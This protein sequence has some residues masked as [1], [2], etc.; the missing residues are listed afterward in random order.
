MLP[1]TLITGSLSVVYHDYVDSLIQSLQL[2]RALRI[3][4]KMKVNAQVT[5]LIIS[6]NIEP[7]KNQALGKF[8]I[9]FFRNADCSI[10]D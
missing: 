4:C 6:T 1:G 7:D 9:T 10:Y 3:F 2:K 8:L 5:D